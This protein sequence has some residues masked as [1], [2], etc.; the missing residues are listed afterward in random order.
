MR[1]KCIF[2]IILILAVLIPK[3]CLA[4]PSY[5]QDRAARILT[6]VN[7]NI[8]GTM[9]SSAEDAADDDNPGDKP[10]EEPGLPGGGTLYVE[11]DIDFPWRNLKSALVQ[12]AKY[13][14]A[15]ANHKKALSILSI[16]DD[17]FTGEGL[18][19]QEI[20]DT[21][22]EMMIVALETAWREAE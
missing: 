1:K 9:A 5:D 3:V 19:P 22:D 2:F 21:F 12:T 15:Q 17:V 6:K 10:S 16:S 20:R 18:S 7:E 13:L 11:V 8:P 14:T 4:V